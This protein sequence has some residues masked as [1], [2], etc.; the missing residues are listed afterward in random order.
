MI[1]MMVI[2]VTMM[3][4]MVTMK[5]RSIARSCVLRVISD[6]PMGQPTNKAAY[7]VACTRLIIILIDKLAEKDH[8]DDL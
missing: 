1:M 4:M 7:R 2:M 3:M 5:T 8:T 6:R